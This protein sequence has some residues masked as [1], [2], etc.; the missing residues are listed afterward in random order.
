[1]LTKLLM[2]S[3]EGRMEIDLVVLACNPDVRGK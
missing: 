2:L 3:A 1:M